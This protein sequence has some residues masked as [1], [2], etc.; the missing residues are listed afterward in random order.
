MTEANA[1]L[2]LYVAVALLYGTARANGRARVLLLDRS[3]RVTLTRALACGAVLGSGWLWRAVESGAAA[4]LV[5]LTGLMVMGTVVTLLGPVAP[6]LV[7]ALAVLAAVAVA[8]LVV[9]GGSS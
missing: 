4:A 8:V 6:R 2:L 1:V 5:V 7:W 3:R 9:M